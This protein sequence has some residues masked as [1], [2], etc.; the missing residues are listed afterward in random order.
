MAVKEGHARNAM[1]LENARYAKGSE[2]FG[3]GQTSLVIRA[4]GVKESSFALHAMGKVTY[5]FI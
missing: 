5:R 4:R 1:A 3:V 2:Q